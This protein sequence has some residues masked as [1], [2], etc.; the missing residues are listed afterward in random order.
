METPT[1]MVSIEISRTRPY[2]SKLNVGPGDEAK[3]DSA[4]YII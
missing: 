4:K 3:S 1:L 2:S